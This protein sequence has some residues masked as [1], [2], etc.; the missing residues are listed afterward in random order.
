MTGLTSTCRA[1]L[2]LLEF[3]GSTTVI[4]AVAEQCHSVTE[5]DTTFHGFQISLLKVLRL[6][7]KRGG[8]SHAFRWAS[9]KPFLVG[10]NKIRLEGLK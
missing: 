3:L 2:S 7:A 1:V 4:G 9:I 5:D 10:F 8:A 6:I